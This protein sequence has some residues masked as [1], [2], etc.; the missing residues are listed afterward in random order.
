MLWMLWNPQG[1]SWLNSLTKNKKHWSLT[2]LLSQYILIYHEKFLLFCL[3]F[4]NVFTF[5]I[6]CSVEALWLL[7]KRAA[8]FAVANVCI[9]KVTIQFARKK[10]LHSLSALNNLWLNLFYIVVFHPIGYTFLVIQLLLP[11]V[12]LRAAENSCHP[13]LYGRPVG[14][15]SLWHK[16]SLKEDHL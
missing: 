13:E 15:V 14:S 7:Q 1:G 5:G 16:W 10:S 9:F 6:H 2:R 12:S 3:D 11:H 4:R 8:V